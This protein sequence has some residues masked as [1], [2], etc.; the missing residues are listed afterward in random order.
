MMILSQDKINACIYE[1]CFTLLRIK[2]E[3]FNNNQ[4]IISL[5]IKRRSIFVIQLPLIINNIYKEIE[6]I[7]HSFASS[8]IVE[9]FIFDLMIYCL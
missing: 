6:R 7:D 2:Y 3:L 9:D 5:Y 8:F 4:N 1:I